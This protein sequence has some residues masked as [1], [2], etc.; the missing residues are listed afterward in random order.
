MNWNKG[1]KISGMSGHKQSEHQKAVKR[2]MNLKDN[3]SKRPEIKQKMRL[4]K[5]GKVGLNKGKHWKVSKEKL[6]SF[7]KYRGEKH[8]N[9]KGGKIKR[10]RH[11]STKTRKY[12][13]W[14]KSVFERDGYTC[15]ICR[16]VGIYLEPHH[17]KGWTHYPKLRFDVNNGIALCRECHKLTFK[18][19]HRIPLQPIHRQI[20]L[21]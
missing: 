16:K 4:A 12:L 18:Q 13:E 10:Y 21:R 7:G 11:G 9:W 3:P 14:K 5:L 15:Q 20:G 8:W 6:K 19:N 2:E 1:L 17:I